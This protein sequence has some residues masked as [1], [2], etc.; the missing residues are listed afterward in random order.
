[1]QVNTLVGLRQKVAGKTHQTYIQKD[2]D[3]MVYGVYTSHQI[4]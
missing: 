1:M 4:T 3:I 2:F